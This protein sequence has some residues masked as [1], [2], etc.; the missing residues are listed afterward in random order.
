MALKNKIM[1]NQEL[2]A[3]AEFLYPKGTK[4]WP[5]GVDRRHKHPGICVIKN[6]YRFF[7]YFL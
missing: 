1:T 2:V 5:I 6:N 7:N 4:Y 3:K